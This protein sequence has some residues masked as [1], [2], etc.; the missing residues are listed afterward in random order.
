MNETPHWGSLMTL[1]DSQ[2][3]CNRGPAGL[4]SLV[5]CAAGCQGSEVRVQGLNNTQSCPARPRSD[6]ISA[7]SCCL[8][9]PG[10]RVGAG[11]GLWV[12]RP[13]SSV[14][15]GAGLSPPVGESGFPEWS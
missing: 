8:G 14:N 6:P 15:W 10:M 4:S 9:G 3:P 1:H 12:F 13:T 5:L 2:W 7:A 11:P